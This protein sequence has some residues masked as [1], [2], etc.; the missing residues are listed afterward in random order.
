[1]YQLPYQSLI[2]HRELVWE[3]SL[4]ELKGSTKGALLGWTWIVL[5]PLI[6]TGAYVLVTTL[7]FRTARSDGGPLEYTMYVL[8]GMVPW[9]ILTKSLEISPSLIRE[10]MEL[11]KQV[12][13]PIETLPLTG[14][15]AGS[16]GSLVSLFFF[17]VL[18]LASG[19]VEWSWLLLP[20]PAAILVLF[21][22]GT[23]WVFM[24][25]GVLVKDLREIVA[26]ILNLLVFL[27]PV[28]ASEAMV[29]EKTWALLMWNPL[30]HYVI[31]F[32]DVFQ[33]EFHPVSWIVASLLALVMFWLGSWTIQKTKVLI[34]E[35]L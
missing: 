3:M 30:A 35:Y 13:Y 11:V 19:S 18:A 9:Q 1:M 20:L 24:I 23:S 12:I 8:A 26:L 29:G 22:M 10:R 25:A 17:L 6:Q 15:I 4:R 33:A 21:V 27:S 34:N 7:I 31:C 16:V 32:R 28:V 14:M 2:R 5:R